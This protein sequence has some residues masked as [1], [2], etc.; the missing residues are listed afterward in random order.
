M[1]FWE[2][3]EHEV[4]YSWLQ[5]FKIMA[6]N[7]ALGTQRPRSALLLAKKGIPRFPS[8]FPSGSRPDPLG[9]HDALSLETTRNLSD[10]AV[11]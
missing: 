11:R 2:L 1:E 8:G 5:T 9:S 10:F 7:G 4:A 6:R 3:E